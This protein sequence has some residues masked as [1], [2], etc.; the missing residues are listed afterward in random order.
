MD[1]RIS[2][3]YES[4]GDKIA[5]VNSILITK[6]INFLKFYTVLRSVVMLTFKLTA[7]AQ[8]IYREAY[9]GNLLHLFEVIFIRRHYNIYTR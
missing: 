1:G 8:S 6:S 3:K 5:R 9:G 2:R 7:R 4:R